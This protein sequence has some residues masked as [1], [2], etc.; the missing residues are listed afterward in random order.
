MALELL[1]NLSGHS[2][3]ATRTTSHIL[4]G[5]VVVLSGPSGSG[6]TV[7][8]EKIMA[9][10]EDK[11]CGTAYVEARTLASED[12]VFKLILMQLAPESLARDG[13]LSSSLSPLEQLLEAL[14]NQ[15][16]EPNTKAPLKLI[17]LDDADCLSPKFWQGLKRVITSIGAKH[18]L[19]LLA[20]SHNSCAMHL[21]AP[22]D[23]LKLKI[24]NLEMPELSPQDC[25]MVQNAMYQYEL[26]NLASSIGAKGYEANSKLHGVEYFTAGEW[27]FGRIH[28]LV[29]KMLPQK[30]NKTET[31]DL[32]EDEMNKQ[33][34]KIFGLLVLCVTVLA[35][36]LVYCVFM[37]VRYVEQKAP[38]TSASVLTA[39]AKANNATTIDEA[40]T[41]DEVVAKLPPA[42]TEENVV[43]KTPD[44]KVSTQIVVDGEALRSIEQGEA[45]KT[46]PTKNVDLKTQESAKSSE[47]QV[48][49]EGQTK[50]QTSNSEPNLAKD[51]ASLKGTYDL[52]T[53]E[54]VE[55]APAQTLGDPKAPALT[56][57]N[58]K[59]DSSS[60]SVK[61]NEVNTPSKA[62]TKTTKPET[63]KSKT[64]TSES[65][66]A[67]KNVAQVDFASLDGKSYVIQI[68]ATPSQKDALNTA[69]KISAHPTWVL[70]RTR[71]D[72]IAVVG[73]FKNYTAAKN[74]VAA[75]PAAIK[76]AG[77]WPKQ[78][79][80]VRQDLDQ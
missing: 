79:S 22:L 1:P 35:A 36:S 63:V 71:G 17:V 2:E 19:A 31:T 74:A 32:D 60:L 57:L 58:G 66:S 13:A 47:P 43:V 39:K 12:V 52:Q 38:E 27:T 75:F 7:F 80:K 56:N 5:G 21:L 42:L 64:A 67:T 61:P 18:Q 26:H 29:E 46:I 54:V 16:L 41:E 70:K 8:C 4:R 9:S 28:T 30:P 44:D 55:V 10:L 48:K 69:A 24:L 15:E 45:P 62:T 76:K 37:Y 20:T 53:K 72:Y 34:N 14:S 40:K 73:S 65:V 49:N 6:R 25:V 77:P 59:E 3:L 68:I 78:V 11:L 23:E 50:T 51:D 33:K